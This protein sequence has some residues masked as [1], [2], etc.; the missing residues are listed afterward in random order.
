MN[1]KEVG[2]LR[3]RFRAEKNAISRIYGCYVNGSSKEMISDLSQ[4]VGMMPQEEAEKFLSFFRQAL[5]GKPGKNL[6]DIVFSTQQ[7]ME[8]EEHRLLSALRDSCLQDAGARQALYRKIIGNLEMKGGNYLILL[9]HDRYDVPHRG[10]DDALQADASEEVFFDIACCVCP[11]K[12]GKAELGYV[13][14]ENEFHSR[15]AAQI[16]APPD[17]GFLFPA[18]DNRAA[19]LYNALFYSRKADELHQDFIDAVFHTEVPM[20]A[21]EQKEAFQDALCEALEEECSMKVLQAMHEQLAEK[22]EEHKESKCPEALTLT[23]GEIGGMLRQCG[24][25]EEKAAAFRQNCAERFGEQ[26]ALSPDNLIDKGH[27]EVKTAQATV[28]VDPACSYLVETR[29]IDGRKYVLIPADEV[30]VNGL[31]VVIK[32]QEQCS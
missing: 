13:P 18:F 27:F 14:G 30:E 12:D 24:A 31:P 23:P 26:A 15:A 10:T 28:S 11:V 19:N 2:E 7:V 16:V 1:Q 25:S 3:R 6:I 8:G 17:L 21:A 20:S 5:S 29:V 22:I 32:G 4:S 9:A